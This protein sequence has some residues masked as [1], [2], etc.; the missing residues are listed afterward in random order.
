MELL[1]FLKQIPLPVLLLVVAVLVVVT[2][3]MA[4]QYLKQKG[5]EGIRADVYV[6]ILKAEH[7][8]NSSG[9]GKQKLK[10]VVQEARKL[11]PAWLQVFI[12]EAFLEKLIDKWFSGVKDLLDDGKV[13][14]SDKSTAE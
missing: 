4:F 11:L 6:L 2:L 10:W 3:V 14:G 9:Q 8:Y 5:L 12:T 7:L 13:N 1:E